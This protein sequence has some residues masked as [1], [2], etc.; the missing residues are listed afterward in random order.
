MRWESASAQTDHS[1]SPKGIGARSQRPAHAG[2]DGLHRQG[3][4]SSVGLRRLLRAGLVASLAISAV[5]CAGGFASAPAT[6]RDA[7]TCS[8]ALRW[9]D[10]GDAG[11]IVTCDGRAKWSGPPSDAEVTGAQ[12]KIEAALRALAGE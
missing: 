5:G 1:R 12:A 11:F 7:I 4:G 3:E 10:K 6:Y 8:K 9:E 2:E